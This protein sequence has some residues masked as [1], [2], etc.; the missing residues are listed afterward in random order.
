MR[1]S[2][3]II[4]SFMTV[5]AIGQARQINEDMQV[6][7][8]KRS[9]VTY[10]PP[11]AD[12]AY[13]MPLIISLHGGLASPKGQFHLADFRPLADRDQFM[14]ICPASKHI[15]HDGSNNHGIDDVKFIDQ[16]ITYA[17]NTYHADPTRVYVTGISNGGFMTSRLACELSNRIAAFA[18]V[19][20]TMDEGEG[21]APVKAMPVIYMHGTKDPVFPNKGGK[22]FGRQVY[23]QTQVLKVWADLAHCNPEPVITHIPDAAGDSTSV[24]KEVYT[25]PANG[26]KVVGYTIVNGGHT[27]PGGWQ[28][29]PKFIIG[30]TTQ[31][32]NAC[33]EIWEF[34]KGYRLK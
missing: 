28:Y 26:I 14:V 20:G 34:F 33:N 10:L 3:I 32:L 18:V 24:V 13:R 19:A 31:N 1:L 2:L 8:M 21:Y 5:T 6:D 4:L 9:F 15:F 25:N 27:W 30:K 23:S 16:I 29:M 12:K 7:G 11:V 17:I 22:V